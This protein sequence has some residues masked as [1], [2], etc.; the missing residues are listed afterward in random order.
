M[1]EPKDI[2][3]SSLSYSCHRNLIFCQT[4][5]MLGIDTNH[6][7]ILICYHPDLDLLINY[8]R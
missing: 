2:E 8:M 1:A 7:R 4:L 6:T 3:S 5:E